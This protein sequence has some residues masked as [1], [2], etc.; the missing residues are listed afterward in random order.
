VIGFVRGKVLSK[1]LTNTTCVILAGPIGYE[2]TVSARLFDSLALEQEVSL[3]LHTHV[4]EDILALYGFPSDE[5][6]SFFRVLLSVNGLGPKHA[7]SLLSEHGW[8]RL[9]HYIVSKNISAISEAHGVGKTLAQRIVLDLAGKIEKLAILT[10]P[11]TSP[12]IVTVSHATLESSLKDDLLS[13]LNNLGYQPS[14][15]KMTLDRLFGDETLDKMGFESALKRAL[16]ELSGRASVT[17]E[18]ARHA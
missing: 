10:K 9:A 12:A 16:A 1:S 15:I 6:K 18:G 3:W 14:H 2:M 4:R 7:L 11:L 5:E 17:V 13:A 8:D